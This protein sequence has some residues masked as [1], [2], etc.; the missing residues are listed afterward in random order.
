[1]RGRGMLRPP[2]PNPHLRIKYSLQDKHLSLI[3]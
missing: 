1:M 2:Y 3:I